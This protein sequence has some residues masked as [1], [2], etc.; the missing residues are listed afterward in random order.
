MLDDDVHLNLLLLRKSEHAR[1]GSRGRRKG[2]TATPQDMQ[3]GQ[4]HPKFTQSSQ[5]TKANRT[6]QNNQQRPEEC[7]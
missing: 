4:T 1:K 5:R 6:K 2:E 3:G 7:F